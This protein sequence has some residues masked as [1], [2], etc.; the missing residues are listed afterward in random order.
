M[1][2]RSAFT[3]LNSVMRQ[4]AIAEEPDYDLAAG[5]D[6]LITTRYSNQVA[7]IKDLIFDVSENIVALCHQ[8]FVPYVDTYTRTFAQLRAGREYYH[9]GGIATLNIH[10]GYDD[11]L[12]ADSVVWGSTT[13]TTAQYR[14][15]DGQVYPAC[16]LE[17]DNTALPGGGSG[18]SDGINITGVW[19]YHP[20]PAQLWRDSGNTVQDNPLSSSATTLNVVAG[21]AFETYQYIRIAD[22][23]LFITGISDNALTVERGVNGTT[24]AAHTQATQIDTLRIYEVAEA[25]T[26]RRVVYLYQNPSETRRVVALPD[27]TIELGNEKAIPLPPMRWRL[28]SI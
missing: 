24:A 16:Y 28:G 17:L 2:Y 13:L 27:G 6:T 3:T 1:K 18:F 25:A 14:V 7:R 11:L 23:Y 22:E 8:Q 9:H 5:I 20:N 19:G 21:T 10:H 15:G 4:L 26:R 12:S